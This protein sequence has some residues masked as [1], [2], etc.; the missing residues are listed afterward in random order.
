MRMGVKDEIIRIMNQ[1]MVAA[2]GKPT[3]DTLLGFGV[4]V[5]I[6]PEYYTFEEMLRECK[7]NDC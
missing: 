4:N 5:G 1:K 3:C 7:K 6:M 2:I